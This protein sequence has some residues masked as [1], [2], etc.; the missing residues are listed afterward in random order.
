YSRPDNA[1][2]EGMILAAGAEIADNGERSGRI[3]PGVRFLVVGETPDLGGR[4]E[5]AAAA[6]IAKLGQAKQRATEAGVTV[7][8]AWKLQAYLKTLDD[9]LTTPL[10]SAVRGEDFPPDAVA[11]PARRRPTDLPDMFKTQKEQVQRTND[12]VNP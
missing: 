11:G 10:G 1:D 6:D 12:I 4:N 5:D 3:D 8:P 2:L 9:S 7:I